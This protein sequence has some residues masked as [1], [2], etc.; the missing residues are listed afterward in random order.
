MLPIS[1]SSR[2]ELARKI[3][4]VMESTYSREKR[5]IAS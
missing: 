4:L 1:G 2:R 3:L 5:S